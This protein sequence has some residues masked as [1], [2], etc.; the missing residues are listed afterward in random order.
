MRKIIFTILIFSGLACEKKLEL[1]FIGGD[2]AP[3]RRNIQIF[4]NTAGK[5]KDI[6]N[7]NF[8]ILADNK[9]EEVLV[10]CN[11]ANEFKMDGK[12]VIFSGVSKEGF[13]NE[14]RIGPLFVLS[15]IKFK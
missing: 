2:C 15:M 3:S 4:Q 12:A 14:A 8:A 13:P 1:S 11:L 6:G 5:I 7:G 10:P 9:P